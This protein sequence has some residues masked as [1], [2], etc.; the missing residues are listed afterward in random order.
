VTNE[1]ATI[2][3]MCPLGSGTERDG[4]AGPLFLGSR[5]GRGVLGVLAT[6]GSIPSEAGAARVQLSA[7]VARA[8]VLTIG[9][10]TE[11]DPR[12][13]PGLRLG[14]FLASQDSHPFGMGYG[15]IGRGRH[16]LS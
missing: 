16:G 12:V 2:Q 14:Q 11:F 1:P 13:E 15:H 6:A 4:S 7:P 8:V 5:P 10:F 9:P 3:P